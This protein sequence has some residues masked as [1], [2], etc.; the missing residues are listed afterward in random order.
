MEFV[1]AGVFA[2]GRRAWRSIPFPCLFGAPSSV[3]ATRSLTE[4]QAADL[5]SVHKVRFRLQEPASWA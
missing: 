5:T 2:D 1:V 3:F 4:V